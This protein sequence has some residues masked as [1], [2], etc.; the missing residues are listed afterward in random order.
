[1]DMSSFSWTRRAQAFAATV[2]VAGL[3]FA[4]PA[5]ADTFNSSPQRTIGPYTTGQISP[6]PSGGWQESDDRLVG[7]S[8]GGQGG[9]VASSARLDNEITTAAAHSGNQ[10][11]RV[12]NWY[13]TG[14]V[15]AFL[16]PAVGVVGESGS[17]TSGG[18]SPQSSHI[19]YGFWFMAPDVANTGAQVSSSLTDAAGRRMTYVDVS[20]S[21]GSV[22]FRS[23][24]V[25]PSGRGDL[26]APL[27]DETYVVDESEPL[28]RGVW[29]HVVIDATFNDGEHNDVVAVTVA[30]ANGTE[31]FQQDNVFSWEM[32]YMDGTFATQGT[33]VAVDHVGFRVIESADTSGR[34]PWDT[35]SVA[36]RPFGFYIDDLSVTPDAGAGYTTD[37][38]NDRWVATT[39]SDSGDCS[40]ETSPCATIAYALT[41][42]GTNATVHVA[43]GSYALAAPLEIAQDGLRL[44]GE[45][46]T[47]PQIGMASGGPNQPMLVVNDG[48]DHR[49]TGVH[50]QN[51][52]FDMDQSHVAE[53]ILASGFVDGLTIS[54]N[55][56]VNSRS[57]SG[58]NA[59]YGFRNA[60]SINDVRNSLSLGRYNGS[61]VTIS[62]NLIDGMG[63]FDNGVYLRAG[64]DMDA[65]LG[66]ISGNVIKTLNHDIHIRFAT[67]TPQSTSTSISITGNVLQGRGLEFDAPNASVSQVTID[68]NAF[69]ALSDAVGLPLPADWSLVRLI[70]N[71]QN[72]PTLVANNSFSGYGGDFRGV[73]VENY[74]AVTLTGNTF[75]PKAGATNFVSLVLSNKEISSDVPPLLPLPIGITAKGNSFGG[76]GTYG[77]TAVELLNDNDAGGTAAYGTLLFG[78]SA[79]GEANSF[80]GNLRWYFHLDNYNCQTAGTPLCGYLDYAGVGSL[81]D[82]DV[83]PFAGNVS[84]ADN[85]FD[86]VMPADMDSVQ[87]GALLGRTFDHTA[88]AGLG[89]VNYDITTSA[90]LVTYVDD[91][92]A[93]ASYGQEFTFN[94]ASAGCG[95]AVVHVGIDAFAT[96]PDGIN[97]VESGGTVCVAKG[98]Y[99]DAVTLTKP[100]QLI[101]DGHL[102]G[103][104][105]IA[106]PVV[107]QASGAEGEPLVLSQLRVSNPAGNGI[108]ISG[109]SHLSFDNI[110]ASDNAGSGIDFGGDDDD[111]AINNSVFQANDIGLRTGSTANVSNLSIT[112][113]TFT[114]NRKV[115]ILPYGG[116]GSGTGKLTNWSIDNTQFHSNDG[117][118][119]TPWGGALW[120]KTGGPGSA[121]DGFSVTN[122][123]FADNG[124]SNTLN[125]VG[126]TVR[127]RAG[128]TM[129]NVTICSN[130]FEETSTPGTQLTGINVVDD[131]DNDYEPIE[132]CSNNTFGDGLG[133]SV[134][135]L[136]Q[137]NKYGTQPVVNITGGS[138]GDTDH[139][140]GFVTRVRD[141]AKFTSIM[142]A[143]NDADTQDN[144]EI[145]VPAGVYKENVVISRPGIRLIGGG[146][147][148]PLPAPAA[149]A[150]AGP[151]SAP[152]AILDGT[153]LTGNGVEINGGA[154]N[155]TVAGFEI[156]NYPDNCVRAES[157]SDGLTVQNNVIHDCGDAGHDSGIYINVGGT[158]V[159]ANI[160]YNSI[161]D[162]YDHG[163]AIWNGSKQDVTVGNNLMGPVGSTAIGFE[164]GT[165]TGAQIVNNTIDNSVP[166]DPSGYGGDTGIAIMQLTSGSPSNRPNLISHNTITNPGRFG[167]ALMIPNGTGADS[168]DGAIVVEDNQI[169]GGL[170]TGGW[171]TDD[172]AGI[173]VVRRYYDDSHE[174]GQIDVTRGVVI[175]GNT[176]T[177]FMHPDP[178][179]A[180]T[181]D[182]GIVVEGVGSSVSGN[183]LSGNDIGL[184]IQQGNQ[185]STL[186]GNSDPDIHTVWFDR[187]NTAISCVSVGSND[188]SDNGIDQRTV[189]N[190]G[191][192][193]AIDSVNLSG[194][195]HN[196][197]AYYCS[198]NAAIA[199]ANPGDSITVG[200]G[201]YPENVVVD[202]SVTLQGP[203][204][205]TAGYDSSRD[206]TGEA[207]INPASGNALKI[208]ADGVTFDGFTIADVNDDAIVA[209]ADSSSRGDNTIITNNRVV[210]VNGGSGLFTNGEPETPLS[211]WT[212]NDNL[213]S[214]VHAATGSGINLWD[215]K[216]SIVS[217]NHLQDMGFAG[218]QL[219]KAT[220]VQVTGNTVT[221]TGANGISA[222]NVSDDITISGNTIV[223]ANTGNNANQAGLTLSGDTTN[224]AM[225]CNSVSGTSGHNGFSTAEG[226]TG[227]TFTGNRIF[228]NA[229][230]VGTDIVHTMGLTVDIG[231]NWYGGD[232]ASVSGTGVSVADP[233]S[234][235]PI[236][237]AVCTNPDPATANAPTQLALVSGGGQSAPVT[238]SF[239]NPLVVRV[240]DAL[241]GAVPGQAITFVAPATGAS[242]TLS[243]ASG[244]SDA[245]GEVS[246]NATAN[247]QAGP[248]VV[249]A[250][251]G[252]LTLDGG[253][254]LTN[255]K[256]SGTVV[257][258][259]MSFTYDGNPHALS[260]SVAEDSTATCTLDP[261]TITDAGTYP[262]HAECV[263]A[264]YTASG[265][266]SATVDKATGTVVFDG[267]TYT[268]S[269][270]NATAHIAEEPATSC[271]VTPA[272]VGPGAG[273]TSASATCTGSNYDASGTGVVTIAKA[274]STISF[275]QADLQQDYGSTH[276]VGVTTSPTITGTVDVTYDGNGAVPTEPGSYSVLATIDDP[277]YTGSNSAV[278]VI[279][280]A[281]DVAL[282]IS[283]PEMAL[284]GDEAPYTDQ[285]TFNGTLANTGSATSQ[286]VH[287]E[288]HVVRID[289][290][291]SSN[292]QPMPI[293]LDDV[294]LC[295]GDAS[296]WTAQEPDFHRNC[297]QDYESLYYNES[298]G[299]WNGRPA[300]TFRYPVNPAY[301][302]AMPAMP[303]TDLPPSLVQL[304]PGEYQ[305]TATVV[306][307]DDG[308]VYASDMVT[309][310]VPDAAVSY[311]GPLSGPTETALLSQATL[312]NTGGR[313]IGNVI[314][315]I[316]LSDAGGAALSPTDAE[317]A[318]QDG[319]AFQQLPWTQDGD[320]LVTWYGPATGFELEDGHLA[321]A[322][323]STI[324]HRIGDYTVTYDVLDVDTL[325]T[326]YATDMIDV[327]IDPN[328]VSF[329]L[330]DL[331]Q[332]Y[333]G[334]PHAVSVDPAGATHTV[335]YEALTGASCPAAPTAGS[336]TPPTDAGSY[337]VYVT[338]T[339]SYTGSASGT[340]VIA[341]A[342]AS[343]SLDG[344]VGG[345]ISRDYDGSP[346]AVSATSDPAVASIK[347]TYD[348]SETPP[349][350]AGSYSV[351]AV[352]DDANY[353]GIAT[354]TLVIQQAGTP[355]ITLDDNSDGSSDGT[356]HR[357]FSGGPQAVTASVTPTMAY[358]V[359]YVGDGGTDYPLTA[360]PPTAVG[361]YHVVATTSDANYA[362]TSASGTLVIEPVN[363]SLEMG[364]DTVGVVTV[365]GSGTTRYSL[366]T[367][368][369]HLTGDAPPDLV[370]AQLTVSRSGGIAVGDLD[371]EYAATSDEGS[372]CSA[373]DTSGVWWCTLPLVDNGDGTLGAAFGPSTGFPVVDGH[374]SSFRTVYHRGGTFSYNV[375]I[376]GVDTGA[377]YATATKDVNV[378][379]V[380]IVDTAPTSANT[381]VG[382]DSSSR[383]A[384]VGTAGIGSGNA[385]PNNENVMG[386]VIIALD[387]ATL[388]P[389]DLT[390]TYL[391]KNDNTY[392]VLPL[393]ACDGGKLCA[394]FGP[395]TG[396]NVFTGYDG[397]SLFRTTFAT[398]GTYTITS[399]AVGMSS[400]AVF[401]ET[402]HSLTVQ[403]STAGIVLDVSS[404]SQVY[405]ATHAVTAT[406][407]PAGLAYS[408][409]YDGDAAVPTDAGDYDV[410][411]TITTA[412]Y[413]GST[414]GIL[415][416]GKA[417]ASVTFDPASLHVVY[418]TNGH[419]A[420]ATTAPG[421]FAVD[422]SYDGGSAEP[423][424]AG[425]YTVVA[426]VNDANYMGS[427]TAVMVIDK[428]TATVALGG[429]SAT[430]DGNP[431]AATATTDPDE[432]STTIT[433]DGSTDAPSAVGSYAVVAT[434]TNPNY[435]GSAS[436]TLVISPAPTANV[437]VSITDASDYVRYGTVLDYKINV[438]NTGDEP[439][440]E[441]P[442]ADVLPD[443]LDLD[444]GKWDCVPTSGASV[445]TCNGNG[446]ISDT[447][448]IP[449]GGN[450]AYL[451]S[452]S[453]NDDQTLPTDLV[454]NT[455]AATLEDDNAAD[456][457]AT[458]DTQVVLFRDGFEDGGNG[459]EVTMVATASMQSADIGA[460]A[461]GSLLIPLDQLPKHEGVVQSLATGRDADGMVFRVQVMRYAGTLQTR[462]LTRGAHG[463][464]A[465]HWSKVKPGTPE[466]ALGLLKAGD[467]SKHLM[468]VGASRSIEVPVDASRISA[469]VVAKPV[470]R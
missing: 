269:V 14:A 86:G 194:G 272:A 425:S 166:G 337:C 196:G 36:N 302:Q 158:V 44:I 372:N 318:Y 123:L 339:G 284:V 280:D 51:F 461:D 118:D 45:G 350:E 121:I 453:V 20:D 37:F 401:A 198:I 150:D 245:N 451:L 149:S 357:T 369:M 309:T 213:F 410:V 130:T 432:L 96:I 338:A 328:A 377:T 221:T 395:Q 216:N 256:G 185:A 94:S 254:A 129:K 151:T 139:I 443:T 181:E 142:L 240:A 276:A 420:I 71:P 243:P 265:D 294:Q 319:A 415:H 5:N 266:G 29:Y 305:V 91:A 197:S 10:S 368:T 7:P 11:W 304:K 182:Y 93:G 159:G 449:A 332:V 183:T 360:T 165:A 244:T 230:T 156:R 286:A 112:G 43:S 171:A 9:W 125:Q 412:G 199:A 316:T 228:D 257:F 241:G 428:A 231:S 169:T 371:I 308:R 76:S 314:V 189:S 210:N 235:T 187:G 126:I 295:V 382:V 374:S 97:N 233:L 330:G 283:G 356:I 296:G 446:D 448:S 307:D 193:A 124:S 2:L 409:T 40:V 83:R 209:R 462:L 346:Q 164:D 239:A 466:L 317:F 220:N 313:V 293:A 430:Y 30:D 168:G 463:E 224:V 370:V 347:V 227:N 454:Q 470:A 264:N 359:T 217:G 441:V 101:G 249:D 310:T 133:H 393:V 111:I 223:N 58:A 207:V 375:A 407:T 38:D 137:F 321:T 100:V 52:E 74:P 236:G 261:A 24:G 405:G 92:F 188:F 450:V 19:A 345:Q 70:H 234:A 114:G 336:T 277:N 344:A 178:Q 408:V 427:A 64:I 354:G 426:T 6:A 195:I 262:V 95:T 85:V 215:V 21:G 127:A 136:E 270:Q 279:G 31:V 12:S 259:T 237:T 232:A 268:G 290:G 106:A 411:A 208:K 161:H 423:V 311:N 383:M 389:D 447:V 66:T 373:G 312:A 273:S 341:K 167:L 147:S 8:I 226:V 349:T 131:G 385:A 392:H 59:S 34:L 335:V 326:V 396:M 192:S 143:I 252:T 202:K 204:A 281:A 219:A 84:A 22:T 352:V 400:G 211:G 298:A 177:G 41:Q 146:T 108:Q 184:Q 436:G 288:F 429:L 218:I 144:D 403:A 469:R 355:T 303:V 102:P 394:D 391:E 406:T 445:L 322:S 173:Q 278:L 434:V 238:A 353:S 365:P 414:S 54:G 67:V 343:V 115:G 297:P 98:T 154:D 190:D 452:V 419:A 87:Q 418:D 134:S 15:N 255:G 459:A 35:Y 172:R 267:L 46:A 141:G 437:A 222:G 1:M 458:D 163:I 180:G 162:V 247:D 105:V 214:G 26:A 3:A 289:D 116:S 175:R 291:N 390:V 315:R 53:G 212:V 327:T 99:S 342:D 334:S 77:G 351:L 68:T 260:A 152:V 379:E 42:A 63:D 292:G 306:G 320:N 417:A 135:G 424:D 421:T 148:L 16:S 13:H 438:T 380:Q 387:G 49:V 361:S 348:G 28:T 275:N 444:T 88:D 4:L 253:I 398:P 89:T 170:N 113:S 323:G 128:A 56:F 17:T 75:T 386:K 402:T 203:F 55:H 103:D 397:T 191:G 61:S 155:V 325:Q 416:I 435:R 287:Y 153:G 200:A 23:I 80:D 282:T 331:F 364:G 457:S 225:L 32:A 65:G 376:N 263:G 431:H 388:S 176:V 205:G 79:G 60:I 50:I 285:L 467:G 140:N 300:V 47:Q 122:S 78:G 186:P 248:Y 465:S 174:G 107:I 69:S 258:G 117:A 246:V 468:L 422:Y 104:T 378:A 242:A 404:L 57:G 456:N 362:E 442:L 82:T 90:N 381:G 455:I 464:V 251:S 413:S 157:G 384:N 271:T 81:P 229:L 440:A 399:R 340:L 138:I 62:N 110:A 25:D 160:N 27:N 363:A 119:T 39:G 329:D 72:I 433:Y 299:S 333:D 73:L 201:S 132:V 120:I 358:T 109:S 48:S 250:S 439:L 274:N 33:L 206:G 301:D 460:S 367:D 18:A 145:L 366:S 324:F 179:S